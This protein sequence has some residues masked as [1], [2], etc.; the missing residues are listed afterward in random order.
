MSVDEGRLIA[1]AAQAFSPA[2]PAVVGV[3]VSGGG[4]SLALLHLMLRA[5]P[6]TGWRVEAAT[7]DHRL[8]PEAAEEARRV[9]SLCQAWGIRHETL[10]WDTPQGPGN[11]MDRARKARLR[12]LT[13]WAHRRGIGHVALGHT[14]DDQAET[15]LMGLSR[16][17]GL[18]GLSGMRPR[19]EVDGVTFGRPLLSVPRQALR[20]HLS[21][22]GLTWIDDPTNDNDAFTRA[23]ARKALR[24]LAPLGLT[25]DRLAQVAGHLAQARAALETAAVTAAQRIVLETAGALSLDRAALCAESAEVQRRVLLLALRWMTGADHPPRQQELARL[26]AVLQAEGDATLRGT[27]LRVRGT[28]AW[29]WR[30]GRA[31]AAA[32]CP[33]GTL[34]DGRWQVVGPWQGAE[35]LRCLGAEGLRHCPDWRATGLPWQ[36]LAATP[37]V[38]RGDTLV[39]APCA[40]L[41]TVF[42][43]KTVP[44]FATFLLAH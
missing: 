39:A 38:W 21:S 42:T 23:R 15:L 17:A 19:F 12:L 1:A 26:L 37:A 44:D 43:A 35:D 29:L 5:A 28:Q 4:D 30:E 36:V 18:D 41:G 25:A 13:D 24:A 8:R 27:H 9:A 40:G 7:V 10:V 16:A 33:P 20:D 32:R 14:A 31:A 2:R 3:A 11:L 22:Q 34:W 6:Q